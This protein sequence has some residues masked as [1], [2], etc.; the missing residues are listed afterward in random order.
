MAVSG[1]TSV[2][3][4]KR[5]VAAD[6]K[7]AASDQKLFFKGAELNDEKTLAQSGV[8]DADLV[9]IQGAI[10]MQL[11]SLSQIPPH[12]WRNPAALQEV[13]KGNPK[14]LNQLLHQ[15]PTLAE[16]VMSNNT[17]MLEQYFVEQQRA[18]AERKRME[19]MRIAQLQADP[20]DPMAQ[21]KIQ[22]MIRDKNIKENMEQALEHNPEAFGS[23][24]MLYVPCLVNK[25][26]LKAFVDSGAQMT[27][28][29][30]DCA[31][32]VGLAHLIDKRWQGMAKGVGTAKILGRI[33]AAPIQIGKAFLT[34]SIT[35]LESQDMQFL[36]GLDQLRRHQGIIDLKEN[37]LRIQGQVVPFLSEKDIPKSER[38]AKVEP[39]KK[40]SSSDKKIAPNAKKQK[41]EATSSSKPSA[42]SSTQAAS[43]SS[44]PAVGN[45]QAIVTLMGMGFSD[46]KA[47]EALA[48][49]GGNVEMAAS[50]LFNQQG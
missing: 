26:P 36:F 29:S 42:S 13:I 49:C 35:I 10:A 22:E 32:R 50:Y 41:M 11:Q 40:K 4:L 45:D 46:A 2:G 30:L 15:N 44:A 39:S 34:M 23:V 43:S 16:A 27:I 33:H 1:D 3:T 24:V 14:L 7:V 38:D 28:M 20:L 48:V 12:I 37:C 21:A 17:F 9:E 19:E 31:E 5:L 18:Q 6:F 47:R 8:K 25:K